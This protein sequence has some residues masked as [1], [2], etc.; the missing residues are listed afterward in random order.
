[1]NP[2]QTQTPPWSNLLPRLAPYLPAGL[3]NRLRELSA[4]LEQNDEK[5][6]RQIA[7]ELL[8]ATRALDPLYRVLV[9]YVPRYQLE[10]DP[11]AGQPHGELLEGTFVFADVTGFTALTELLSRQ[12]HTRGREAMNEIMNRLFTSVLDPLTASGGDLLVFIGDAVLAYFPKQDNDNDVFQ[13]TRAAL[14]MQ[15]AVAPFASFE[16]EY[17]QCSLTI[18]VGVERGLAYAGFVG[19]K[20]RMELLVSGPATFAATDA[21]EQGEPGQV[22]LGPQAKAIVQDH[23]TL[24][25]SLVIDDQGEALGDYEI[26]PPTRRSGGSPVLGLDIAEVLQ[27][28][29]TSLQ[30][31]E[32]LAPFLPED[33]LARLVNSTDRHR[34]LESEFRPVAVQFI[35]IAGLEDLA[36]KQGPDLATAALQRYFVQA[37]EIVNRH[38]GVVS[39]VDTYGKG[40]I[41]LNTFGAPRAHEGTKSYAVSAAL[42]LARALDQ[43]N[44]EFKLD[45]PLQQKGGITHGLIFTGEIGAKYRRESVVA[46]PAVNRA[47]RLM[48][49]AQFGQVILDADIWADTQASFVGEK[50]SPVT[51][52]GIDGPVVIINVRQIRRGTRLHPLTRPLLGR[53]A[54]QTRLTEA[55]D[56]LQSRSGGRGTVWMVTGETGIGKT[57]LMSDL[58]AMARKRDLTV[59]VGRCQPHGKHIPLFPWADLLAGWLEIDESAD[60]GQQRARLSAELTSLDMPASENALADLLALPVVEAP[61]R[62]KADVAEKEPV[63]MLAALSDKV[64]Q[65]QPAPSVGLDALLKQRLGDSEE[66]TS[67]SENSVW[68]RLEE[69][70]SGPRVVSKLLTRLAEREPLVVILEDTQ[71]LDSESL[72][73]LND[74]LP[75]V[76][77][78]PLMLVLTGHQAVIEHHQVSS[79]PLPP[80]SHV[81]LAQVAERALG[82]NILDDTLALWIND[83][84]GGNPLYAEALCQA[85]QQSDAILLDRE[86]GEVRWTRLTPALPVSL[87]ELLLARLEELPLTHQDVLKRAAVIGVS[88][89]AQGLLKLCQERMSEQ[90]VLTALER[91]VQASFLTMVGDTT[92]RF[93]HSLMHETIY[94]TLSFAQRQAWHTQVGDWLLDRPK[95]SLELMAYHYLRGA[96][97]KKAA[98]FGCQAGDKARERGIY[99][100]ALEVYEQVLA[101]S[102]APREMLRQA[103]EGRADALALQE[104]YPAAIAAYARAIELGSTSALAKRAI[105]I[106][107]VDISSK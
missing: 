25:G 88:F 90:E 31:V 32:R 38:E 28:L 92:Y 23:F 91:A 9:H 13:A 26:S 37:Q 80:L 45:P 17:G 10:L 15:R 84:A 14:R 95:T 36:V 102:E 98:Q 89:E 46:G 21:E 96:D 60:L 42:Q 56:S 16:T 67:P 43:V 62:A 1:M 4:D 34:R 77:Q 53:E 35:F 64:Q 49:K 27:T 8:A 99:I 66:T 59:L 73:L 104:D 57:S 11:T 87:H 50:L 74:L 106:G 94:E 12:G 18:S 29:E 85:L 101:L 52:K 48:G 93:N 97:V 20:H 55:L 65:E 81:A 2:P 33:M 30:R 63:S 100:G 70:V 6:Q 76:D 78:L 41:L 5:T 40:F 22:I 68:Q 82:G 83:Q 24:E 58:A 75:Q 86:T 71:W 19:T 105:L 51:L 7:Q 79:L 44:R 3:F 54:E 47:A 107:D 72:R 103:A 69:R 39:Q 61:K